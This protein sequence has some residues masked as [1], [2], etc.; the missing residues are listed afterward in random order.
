MSA[1]DRP[2]VRIGGFAVGLVAV[3]A[4]ALGAGSLGGPTVAA[5]E[6]DE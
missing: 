3:F 6:P 5:P 4:L 1:T 2:A